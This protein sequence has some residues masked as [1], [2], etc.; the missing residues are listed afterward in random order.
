MKL[1]FIEGVKIN[2][3]IYK[4]TA[5]LYCLLLKFFKLKLFKKIYQNI[6][7]SMIILFLISYAV[8]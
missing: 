1:L 7:E 4:T 5:S 8:A 2:L 3:G 6:R